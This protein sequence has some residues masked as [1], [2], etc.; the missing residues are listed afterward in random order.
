MD[1]TNKKRAAK[2]T[3]CFLIIAII[4]ILLKIIKIKWFTFEALKSVYYYY[5]IIFWQIN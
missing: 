5:F 3:K 1:G 4:K 2:I